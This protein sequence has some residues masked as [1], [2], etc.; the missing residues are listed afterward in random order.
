MTALDGTLLV[1]DQTAFDQR[2]AQ[3]QGRSRGSV[4]SVQQ[5]T[6][7]DVAGL[8]AQL[9]APSKKYVLKLLGVPEP[10]PDPKPEPSGVKIRRAYVKEYRIDGPGYDGYPGRGAIEMSVTVDYSHKNAEALD[11]LVRGDGG[12]WSHGPVMMDLIFVRSDK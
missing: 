7:G 11:S 12:A 1:D 6:L 5:I 9:D 2:L 10:K 4:E 3:L 8:V